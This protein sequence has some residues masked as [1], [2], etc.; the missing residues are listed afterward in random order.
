MEK[1]MKQVTLEEFISHHGYT[2]KEWDD[3]VEELCKNGVGK[4]TYQDYNLLYLV[5]GW[6]CNYKSECEE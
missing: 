4:G 6:L 5:I 1:K 3:T 2:K